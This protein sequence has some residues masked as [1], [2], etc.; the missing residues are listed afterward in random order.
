MTHRGHAVISLS[1]KYKDLKEDLNNSFR[2]Q[3]ILEQW[4]KF[5]NMA[6]EKAKKRIQIQYL[7]V[8]KFLNAVHEQYNKEIDSVRDKELSRFTKYEDERRELKN[9]CIKIEKVRKSQLYSST[10]FQLFKELKICERKVWSCG[11]ENAWSRPVFR[12]P[13]D[14][15]RKLFECPQNILGY[16]EYQTVDEV[17]NARRT[18]IENERSFLQFPSKPFRS[19]SMDDIPKWQRSI[20]YGSSIS[21]IGSLSMDEEEVK[22]ETLHTEDNNETPPQNIEVCC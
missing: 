20:S 21:S 14:G 2:K 18:G 4:Q 3:K 9:V 17:I 10:F 13:P 11:V 8:I 1:Q 16:W 7:N 19:Q 15:N 5:V 6:A 12:S 22:T